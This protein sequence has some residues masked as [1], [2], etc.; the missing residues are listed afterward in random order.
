M[1]SSDRAVERIVEKM[2]HRVT[3]E[4]GHRPDMYIS[5]FR[6]IDDR[7][8][9][10]LLAYT[11][12]LGGATPAEL[13]EF[14]KAEFQG[15]L[16][17]KLSTARSHDNGGKAIALA[18]VVLEVRAP[19]RPVEDADHMKIITSNL[20]LDTDLNETWAVESND[21]G[22][23]YLKRISEVDIAAILEDR[24]ARMATTANLIKFEQVLDAGRPTIGSVVSYYEGGEFHTGKVVG[25]DDT[26]CRIVT[27]D[28]ET[29]RKTI[30]YSFITEV[31]EVTAEEDSATQKKL[32]DYYAK[33][34]GDSEYAK[35]LVKGMGK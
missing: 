26:S 17:P 4:I 1:E 15:Q 32:Q 28:D 29:N 13:R 33:A 24:K 6:I 35:R 25:I 14:V 31:T 18:S 21:E 2:N 22:T 9:Q 30:A 12:S 19:T 20:Y 8:A 10:V 34:F 23:A 11:D 16:I 7:T 3:A 27:G 5:D